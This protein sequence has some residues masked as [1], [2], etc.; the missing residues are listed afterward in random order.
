MAVKSLYTNIPNSGGISA[1]KPAY[2]SYPEKSVA[3]KVIITFLGLIL[4]LNY[5][6]YNSKKYLQIRGCIMGTAC[7]PSYANI[8]A[9]K[10]IYL[11]IKDKVDLYL[12]YIDNIFFIW[13]DAQ[14]KLKNFFNEIN[15]KHILPSKFYKKSS[16]SK[17]PQCFS[18]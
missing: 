17:I 9:Q 18:L 6:M 14:E 1:V 11:F 8:F 5:F 16:K 10:H 13:K 12:R 7:A 2:E 3:T 15:K 4:A